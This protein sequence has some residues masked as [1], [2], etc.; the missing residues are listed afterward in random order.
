MSVGSIPTTTTSNLRP[1]A[2][3]STIA[4]VAFEPQSFAATRVF[5]RSLFHRFAIQVRQ[6]YRCQAGRSWKRAIDI[7]VAATLVL[8]AA[9]IIAIWSLALVISGSSLRRLPRYGKGVHRFEEL[10]FPVP[11][12]FAGQTLQYLC[13]DHLPVLWNLLRGDL[14]L[15][16]P[17]ALSPNERLLTERLAH[18]RFNDTPGLVCLWWVR[19]RAN[20]AYESELDSDLEYVENQS[21][22]SDVGIAARAFVGLFWG[23]STRVD[24]SKLRVLGVNIENTTMREALDQ[25]ESLA[26]GNQ[27]S[28]VCFVN[29][30]CANWATQH[31][32][33]RSILNSAELTLADGIGIKLA[34]RILRTHLAENVN[35]TDLFPRLCDRLQTSGHRIFLLGACPGVAE[36]VRGWIERNYPLAQVAG[37]QHG[38]FSAEQTEQVLDR[39]RASQSDILLVA[40]GAPR[41]DLWIR[42]HLARTGCKVGIGVGGLFDYYSGRIPRAPRWIRELCLEWF[43][44]FL[45]EPKRLWKR[46]WLGN[47]VFLVRVMMQR[48]LGWY[49]FAC[50]HS[51]SVTGSESEVNS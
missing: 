2:D 36:D 31:A 43:F 25:I 44:R 18:R 3:K 48:C 32:E 33:Y 16:G 14:T 35:G 29:A 8:L 17:R 15:V 7:S 9:P 4:R 51:S 50:D 27:A 1:E 13:L 45:Q 23:L 34:G 28:Q 6:W 5:G 40:M 11:T 37:V 10:R 22:L 30:D 47:G 41:Q 39:I 19:Q 46:Y 42:E 12:G 24:S 20:I 21:L 26:S 38:Y 49:S